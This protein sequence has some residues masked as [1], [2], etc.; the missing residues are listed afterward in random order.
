MSK[1]CLI[2]PPTTG[3]A[4][5]DIYFPMALVCLGARLNEN[6]IPVEIIDFDLDLKKDPSLIH[7][8]LFLNHA[9]QRLEETEGSIFGISSI[10][11][12]YPISL[13]LARELKKRQPKS[14]I[15][16]GGPQPSAIPEETLRVCP[17]IDVIAIGEGETTILDLARTDWREESL[18]KIPGI[19]FLKGNL[20]KVT[21]RRP[22]IENLDLLPF[23]DFSLVPLEDYLAVSPG[24]SLI[25]AGRGCPFLCSFCSTSLMWERNFRVKT[26][27]RIHEEMRVLSAK[28]GLK[29]FGLTHDNF[30]TSH[31]YVTEFC[32]Y[33]ERHNVEGFVW[34]SSA[35]PDTLNPGRIQALYRGGCRGVFLGVDSGSDRIQK[36]IKKHLSIEHY[37]S[38]LA[39]TVSYGMEVISSFILGFSE[40]AEE[41]L[42]RTISLA[43]ESRLAGASS[44]QFHRLAP[45]ASTPVLEQSGGELSLYAG[46]SDVSLLP[47]PSQE[48]EFFIARHPALFSSFY[49]VRTPHIEAINVSA[50]AVFC[51]ALINHAAPVL[52]RTLKATCLNPTELFGV[53]MGWREGNYPEST[54]EESFVLNTFGQFITEGIPQYMMKPLPQSS[55]SVSSGLMN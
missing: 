37:R 12:N 27:S 29:S 25:E 44:V 4:S 19:A 11:S 17:W 53:W 45:L 47:I 14:R 1:I 51:S 22:L 15:I 26:P 42:N 43:L 20:A 46:P 35:R 28:Y 8:D 39:E 7:W 13:L 33:F 52:D 54:I 6:H 50:L 34:S 38:T 36:A 23:P 5:K 16:L 48:I 18:E 3:Q 10:C 2:N 49:S 32:D 9:L 55:A 41:D 30:T 40:E 31:R 24:T 21:A